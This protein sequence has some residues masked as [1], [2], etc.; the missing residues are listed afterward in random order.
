MKKKENEYYSDGSMREGSCSAG[1]I[2]NPHERNSQSYIYNV[3]GND[4][5]RAEIIGIKTAIDNIV[6]NYEKDSSNIIYTDSKTAC[7]M[8]MNGDDRYPEIQEIRNVINDSNYDIKIQDVKSHANTN[9][10]MSYLGSNGIVLS[11]SRVERINYGNSRIDL[12]VRNAR[13]FN[14]VENYVTTPWS[15]R[16]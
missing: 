9:Q 4:V 10:Q 16:I 13:I 15:I 12:D 11:Q 3:G 5:H 8:I 7:N 2:K 14:E 1:Y 6:A